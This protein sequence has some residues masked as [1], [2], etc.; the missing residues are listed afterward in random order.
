MLA[1][2]LT[3]ILDMG[4]WWREETGLPLPLGGN[5]IRRDLGAAVHRMMNQALRDSVNYALHHREEALA[6]AMQYARDL[7]TPSAN[8][9][10]GMYVNERTLRLWRG[11]KDCDPPPTGDGPRTWRD[12]SASSR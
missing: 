7:D 11:W 5:A 9:F 2:G 12:T 3:C 1:M 10:V 6:H 8:R 4:T